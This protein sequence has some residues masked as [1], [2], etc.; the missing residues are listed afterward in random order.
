VIRISSGK[1]FRKD[2]EVMRR[3]GKDLR[4]LRR[5]LELLISGDPLPSNYR[6]HPLRGSFQ[7]ARDSHLEP[8]WLVI[9]ARD[10]KTDEFRLIR[11][12]THQDLFE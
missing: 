8:D 5:W 7:D 10:P 9:Y 3:R 2:V 1:R 4:K 11:T 6:D 12:G